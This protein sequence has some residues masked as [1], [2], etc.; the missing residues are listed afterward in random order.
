MAINFGKAYAPNPVAEL[1]S[2]VGGA[3]Q[4][5]PYQ[6]AQLQQV[7]Q[8][9]LANAL[10]PAVTNRAL[11]SDPTFIARIQRL[12]ALYHLPVPML[13]GGDGSTPD[14]SQGAAP[15]ATAGAGTPA[16]TPADQQPPTVTAAP[17]APQTPGMAIG[18]PAAPAAPAATGPFAGNMAQGAG[19]PAQPAPGATGAASGDPRLQA[20]AQAYT[21][22]LQQAAANPSQLRDPAFHAQLIRAAAAV[23]RGPSEVKMDVQG[24]IAKNKAQGEAAGGTGPATAPGGAPGAAAAAA[25]Q[26]GNPAAAAAV[27]APQAL[28]TGAGAPAQVA[29]AY[30]NPKAGPL[31]IDVNAMLGRTLGLNDFKTL[32][33][34]TP[35]D[36][37][38]ALRQGGYDLSEFDPQWLNSNPSLDPA[39]QITLAH[40]AATAITSD[41]RDGA[42]VDQI[43]LSVA[44]YR[45]Y[46]SAA[47]NAEL[48]ANITDEL[49]GALRIRQA[50]VQQTG[51]LRQQTLD[52][53]NR[54]FNAWQSNV[55][56]DHDYK[57]TVLNDKNAQWSAQQAT[58][59]QNAN[60]AYS[61]YQ[62][63]FAR[64][65]ANG[66]VD[67][68]GR[69]IKGGGGIKPG[70]MINT[71][72]GLLTSINSAVNEY[73]QRLQ[74]AL[75]NPGKT[76]VNAPMEADIQNQ[77]DAY[78]TL[79]DQM[80]ARGMHYFKHYTGPD[81]AAIGANTAAA[82]AANAVNS[83]GTQS[84]PGAQNSPPFQ[85]PPGW[86]AEQRN[87]QWVIVNSKGQVKYWQ[88]SSP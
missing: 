7:G 55:A 79:V 67:A 43:K 6:E 56:W 77:I 4:Q 46:L 18:K 82:T 35:Q 34:M 63:E 41:I 40:D 73:N 19:Q 87:G 26:S 51:F 81:Q 54:K 84:T 27:T 69:P 58:R 11:R 32:S 74:T 61:R 2:A 8:Q 71:A 10:A 39:Q 76:G 33:G 23:G 36:R 31:R 57:Y 78:N 60:T 75:Q 13:G 28:T 66:L 80:D 16:A 86:R 53:M 15:T 49:N 88:G 62:E 65:Q 25:V 20:R 38:E 21:A 48:D 30:G 50:Q 24:A 70:E 22:L 29:D 1:A 9:V 83:Q 64:D 68:Q 17:A 42:T 59:Q 72:R 45:P 14:A 44:T 47:Q 52:L 3:V 5:L 37:I 85:V 12:A